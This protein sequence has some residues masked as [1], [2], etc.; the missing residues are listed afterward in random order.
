V[1]AIH[2]RNGQFVRIGQFLVDRMERWRLKIS[3]RRRL[4]ADRS[5]AALP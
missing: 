4:R 3:I 2:V 1:R 5:G